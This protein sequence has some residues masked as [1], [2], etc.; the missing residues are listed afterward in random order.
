MAWADEVAAV[1]AAVVAHLGETVTYAAADLSCVVDRD[2][3]VLGE[4]DQVVDRVT[5]VTVRKADAEL[6]EGDTLTIDGQDW[7]VARLEADDAH[8]ARWVI[9]RD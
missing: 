2:V 1:D 4:F 6:D 8:M 9:R 7:A 3:A 5:I